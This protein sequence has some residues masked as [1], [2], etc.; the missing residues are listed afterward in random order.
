MDKK[1]GEHSFCFNEQ[2][3]GGEAFTLTT[4]LY[5]N[6]DEE[7]GYYLNQFL[8]LQSYCNSASFELVGAQITPKNLRKLADELEEFFN[9]IKNNTQ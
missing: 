1:L 6:G 3:N 4:E 7:S 5:N 8:T 9:E 2:D